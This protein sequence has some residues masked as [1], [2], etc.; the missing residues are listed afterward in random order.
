MLL[1]PL[2][3]TCRYRSR[4]T[5]G[6]CRG[7]LDYPAGLLQIAA[8]FFQR[9]DVVDL[10]QPDDSLRG[11]VGD[12]PGRHI[13]KNARQPG[14]PRYGA[15]VSEKTFLGRLIVVGYYQQTTVHSGLLGLFGQLYA[16]FGTV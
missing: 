8:G 13:V 11:Q 6:S 15:E 16:F 1:S 7:G 10:G 3:A 2:R 12:G 5:P 4:C 9:D 14:G